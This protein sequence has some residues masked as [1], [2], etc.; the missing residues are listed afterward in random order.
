MAEPATTDVMRVHRQL[1]AQ[2]EWNERSQAST[3]G[4]YARWRETFVEL[5]EAIMREMVR[6]VLRTQPTS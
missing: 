1:L 6:P 3:A 2:S 4:E 5:F